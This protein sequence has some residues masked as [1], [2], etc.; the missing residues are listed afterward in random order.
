MVLQLRLFIWLDTPEPKMEAG[1][2]KNEQNL[3]L[4]SYA[5]SREVPSILVQ[6]SVFGMLKLAPDDRLRAAPGIAH[7]GPGCGQR[8]LCRSRVCPRHHTR[9][10]Y[11]T[12]H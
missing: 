5:A 3:W 9:Y 4:A 2:Q 1:N 8:L 7:F 11:P 10:A 6:R 12:A